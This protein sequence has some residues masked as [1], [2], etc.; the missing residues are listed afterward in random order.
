[1]ERFKYWIKNIFNKCRHVAQECRGI[2]HTLTRGM[3]WG[4]CEPPKPA[5]E[6]IGVNP[7]LNAGSFAL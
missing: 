2:A 3:G 1:M 6:E 7:T 4:S 5:N